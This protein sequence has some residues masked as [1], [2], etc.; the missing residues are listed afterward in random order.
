M[1]G[2]LEGCEPVS[3]WRQGANPRSAEDRFKFRVAGI[4]AHLHQEEVKLAERSLLNPVDLLRKPY[5]WFA[6]KGQGEW[7]ALGISQRPGHRPNAS[8]LQSNATVGEDDL[9][10]LPDERIECGAIDLV[11][12]QHPSSLS[13]KSPPL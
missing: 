3:K 1:S 7:F 12:F 9:E 4:G 5:F 11:Q 6:M 13:R 8:Q 10:S 2:A